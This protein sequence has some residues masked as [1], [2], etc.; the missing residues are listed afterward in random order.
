MLINKNK[1]NQT[2]RAVKSVLDSYDADVIVVRND[3]C[4]VL[5]MNEQAKERLDPELHN[6]A[7]CKRS[8]SYIFP[9]LCDRGRTVMSS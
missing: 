4:G 2:E 1:K 3:G 6:M 7:S 9:G 8:Y 5:C